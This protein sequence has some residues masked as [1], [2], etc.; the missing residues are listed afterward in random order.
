VAF[1]LLVANGVIWGATY[2][3]ARLVTE[4][5]VQPFGLALLHSLVGAL[6]LLPYCLVRFRGIAFD[7]VHI[8]F[9]VVAGALGTA[10]PSLVLFTSA[11][12]VPAGVLAIIG[13]MVPLVT[14]L[15]ALGLRIE[16][17]ELLRSSGIVFGLAAVLMIVVPET[18]LPTP[19]MAGWVLFALLVPVCYSGENVF[20]ALRRPPG[21]DPVMLLCA[22]LFTGAA[23]LAPFVWMTGT[24]VVPWPPNEVTW[25]IALLIVINTTAYLIFLELVRIA[26]PV[27]A[28]QV[29]YVVA[30]SGVFW[31]ILILDEIHSGWIWAAIVTMFLGLAVVSP[32]NTSRSM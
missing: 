16:R 18:S 21:S 28:G 32:H 15:L 8:R 23:M 9:Y 2:S 20:L 27:F 5:G 25:W 3:L 19:A 7:I 1:A 30:V 24:W 13:A 11:A 14:Y 4:A 26:G 22:M 10:L 6:L 29:G 12:H 17:Y 31:G